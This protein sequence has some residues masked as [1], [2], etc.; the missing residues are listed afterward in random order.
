MVEFGKELWRSPGSTTLLRQSH[1]MA[2]GKNC[3]QVSSEHLQGWTLHNLLRQPWVPVLG[4]PQGEKVFAVVW[5]NLLCFSLW[6]LPLVLLLDITEK[7]L[8]PSSLYPLGIHMLPEPSLLLAEQSQLSKS[9]LLS[10]VLQSLISF[11]GLILDSFEG[12]HLSYW[13]VQ[14]WTQPSRYRL[15]ST[16]SCL[17]KLE[18]YII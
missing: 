1:I 17:V 6:P 8:A 3:V 7:I 9:F 13:G 5:K 16:P 12:F 4:L 15:T 18:F 14:H 11:A 2:V 10:E